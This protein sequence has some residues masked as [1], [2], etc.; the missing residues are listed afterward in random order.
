MFDIDSINFSIV[1]GDNLPVAS[2]SCINKAKASLMILNLFYQG[3]IAQYAD[4]SVVADDKLFSFNGNISIS[5]NC[6]GGK[7]SKK[8]DYF[9]II[10][11]KPFFPYLR[12]TG[13][14]TWQCIIDA[15]QPFEIKNCPT[16][17]SELIPR[18][19]SSG[20]KT[21]S[22]LN[23][24]LHFFKSDS[25]TF[26]E[27][28]LVDRFNQQSLPAI[29]PDQNEDGSLDFITFQK[30]LASLMTSTYMDSRDFNFCC[31]P[32]DNDFCSSVDFCDN[33]GEPLMR[34]AKSLCLKRNRMHKI[35]IPIT[36][37][38]VKHNHIY[39]KVI[40]R[41]YYQTTAKPI[42]MHEDSFFWVAAGM[43]KQQILFNLNYIK[44]AEAVVICNSS[45]NAEALQEAND[46]EK[47]GIAFT[48]FICDPDQYDEVDFSPLKGKT[49]FIEI[50]NHNGLSVAESCLEVKKLYDYLFDEDSA[51]AKFGIK[52]IRFILR[53][54]KYP[55]MT[56]VSNLD[57]FLKTVGGNP[58]TVDKDSILELDQEQFEIIL[59]K[60]KQEI[61]RK[62]QDSQDKPFWGADKKT[63]NKEKSESEEEDTYASLIMRPV[64]NRGMATLIVGEPG[65]GKTPFAIAMGGYLRGCD[66]GF[67]SNWYWTKH[68]KV[69][70]DTGSYKKVE[71]EYKVLYLCFDAGGRTM[72]NQYRKDFCPGIDPKDPLF[73][74]EDMSDSKYNYSEGQYFGKFLQL[75]EK[76]EKDGRSID[77]LFIDTVARFIDSD[78][79]QF[80]NLNRFIK[81]FNAHRPDVALV[82][83]HHSKTGKKDPSGGL[84]AYRSMRNCCTL[85][86]TKKQV[87][88]SK[89][90]TLDDPFTISVSKSFSSG[91]IHPDR[92]DFTACTVKNRFQA[93]ASPLEEAKRLR[94][95]VDEYEA[96]G[97]TRPEIASLLDTTVKTLYNHLT[98]ADKVIKDPLQYQDEEKFE[99][100]DEF[101]DVDENGER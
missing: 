14:G 13:S 18:L 59:E 38:H 99:D 76:Y 22:K 3:N 57:E 4:A 94:A 32:N 6:C 79:D 64:L 92:E 53:E 43:P 19:S 77:V 2:T 87:I 45:E 47:T 70:Q 40:G 29:N 82:F 50:S 78:S 46:I 84:R 34:L 98:K 100:D 58:P 26:G 71:T 12:E 69:V 86:R 65:M 41:G 35:Y 81:A 60:A 36:Y 68:N 93:K 21:D 23:R 91:N 83:L 52:D 7:K 11:G 90:P 5:Y 20:K 74:L 51:K 30:D 66:N 54:I 75:I 101:E 73:I 63:E 44:D 97:L 80:D 88:L 56:E 42:E 67:L 39:N 62:K 72:L 49:V 25:R 9:Q 48:G 28:T 89:T 15:A 33:D 95:L 1:G 85:F 55:D 61:D 37:W 96:I 10:N 16:T 27:Y 31:G 8:L 24:A 17:L